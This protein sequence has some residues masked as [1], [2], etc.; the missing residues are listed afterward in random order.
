MQ[1][2]QNN[3]KKRISPNLAAVIGALVLML[4]GFFLSYSY[5]QTKKIKTYDMMAH[6]IYKEENNEAV[7]ETEEKEEKKEET[8]PDTSNNI[9]GI[10]TYIG[11]LSIPKINFNKGFFKQE[12]KE[13]DVE[14]NIFIVN[15]STYPDVDKGN[16]IIA[17]HSGTGW[18]AFF[19]D[20][21]KLDKGDNVTVTYKNVKYNYNITKIYKQ[22]K[23]GKI[24][25]Y[26]DYSK[27]TLTLI[28]C[29][30]NES[31]TQTIYI[32]EWQHCHL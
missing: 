5:I 18:K 3:I 22:Q 27:T 15:G 13:N 21:Y 24:A 12:S 25:I 30:N 2:Q 17:G 9:E 1:S 11:Y 6:Y 8:K 32:A 14:K 20:L 29:T 10:E 16:F 28:T 4:G 31:T 26:R 23:T 7:I 19:N